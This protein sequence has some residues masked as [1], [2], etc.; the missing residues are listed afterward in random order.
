MHVCEGPSR[1]DQDV[2][3]IGGLMERNRD[4]PMPRYGENTV[5]IQWQTCRYH[6]RIEYDAAN[7]HHGVIVAHRV[8]QTDIL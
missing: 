7:R 5:P 2:A 8:R 6:D 3:V 1:L 4:L